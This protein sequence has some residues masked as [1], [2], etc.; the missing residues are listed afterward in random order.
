MGKNKNFYQNN[1]EA[2]NV[3]E[4]P[5][6]EDIVAEAT[7]VETPV[8]KEEVKVEV[9]KPEKKEEKVRKTATL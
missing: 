7:P 6:T 1:E 2:T 9:K 5:V 3:V 8:V 4:T